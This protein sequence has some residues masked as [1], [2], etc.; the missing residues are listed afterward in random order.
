M[1]LELE[2]KFIFGFFKWKD[3]FKSD[4]YKYIN[5]KKYTKRNDWLELK[6]RDVRC[7]LCIFYKFG[8]K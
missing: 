8:I 7:K 1:M 6:F 5:M 2:K 3:K 4:M